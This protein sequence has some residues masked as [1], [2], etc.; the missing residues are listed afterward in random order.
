MTAEMGHGASW[1]GSQAPPDGLGRGLGFGRGVGMES[2]AERRE[3][4]QRRL[5]S[6][7]RAGEVVDCAVRRFDEALADLGMADPEPSLRP[8]VRALLS[9]AYQ[10]SGY[11]VTLLSATAQIAVRVRHTSFGPEADVVGLR[12]AHRSTQAPEQ[13]M[14]GSSIASEPRDELDPAAGFEQGFEQG[15]GPTTPRSPWTDASASR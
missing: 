1:G 15:T 4:A 8:T 13:L 3:A 2:L 11:D 9:L 14:T 7:V 12:P 5:S 6:S 10:L